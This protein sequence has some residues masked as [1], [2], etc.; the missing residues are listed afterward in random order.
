M[1]VICLF[2][3]IDSKINDDNLN[4]KTGEILRGTWSSNDGKRVV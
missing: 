4:T 3:C 1:R 2:V